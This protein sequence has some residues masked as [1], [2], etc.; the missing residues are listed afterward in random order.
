MT[1]NHLRQ[2]TN[3]L[4]MV[5]PVHFEFNAQTA[6]DN[7]F[8]QN[9]QEETVNSTAMAEFSKAVEILKQE[10]VN[11]LV[12]EKEQEEAAEQQLL[13]KTP[14]AV[15]PNNWFGTG[16][17]GKIIVYT[18]ATE[19]RRAETRRLAD[20]MQLLESNGFDFDKQP[21]ILQEELNKIAPS[22]SFAEDIVEGTGALVI[23]HIGGV[24]YAA[25]S[26]RCHP[27]ALTRFMKIRGD[28]FSKSVMFQTKSSTG[29]EFYH[30]NVMLSIGTQFA[31]VCSAS[32][33]ENPDCEGCLSREQVM[34]HLAK[35]RVVIDITLEQAEKYFCANILEVR[36][37]NDETKIVM[38]TSAYNGFTLEQRELLSKFGKIV[39]VPIG[40]AI[41][42]V[43]GGSSRCMLAEV[44]LPR[45]N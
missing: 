34:Q 4:L 28:Q 20:V 17:D 29:K 3:T 8:Q 15:F 6:V 7:E 37:Q 38:S 9:K 5:R 23:D 31:V 43:G 45:R 36:G 27:A 26:V 25:K 33:V 10:G 42:P 1:D 14:D 41:E 32:I 24:V 39:A 35:D 13:E 30:T 2:T 12:L 44:F 22:Q 11:V 18:M 16:R 40:D 21:I 19:N